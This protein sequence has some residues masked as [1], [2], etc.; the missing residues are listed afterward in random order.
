MLA[1]GPVA[2]AASAEIEQ[3]PDPNDLAHDS[4]PRSIDQGIG[5]KIHAAGTRD[6]DIRRVLQIGSLGK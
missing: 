5:L 6:R 2:S 4:W 3:Y 1:R